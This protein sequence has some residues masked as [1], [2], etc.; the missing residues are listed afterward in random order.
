[1]ETGEPLRLP[2]G[3]A[4]F[5]RDWGVPDGIARRGSMLLVHG[6]GEHS[7]RYEHVAARLAALGLEVRGYDLRG[8]GRS[9]GARGSIPY[10]DA[11][12]DDLSFVFAE[13]ARAAGDSGAPLLLG[14]SLG[15]T[16]AAAA[17]IRGLVAPRALILSSPAL[18]VHVRGPRA[19]ALNLARRLI[20]DR[21]LP[22]ALPLDKLSHE[23]AVVAAYRDDELVHDRITPR[24]YGFLVDAGAAARRGAG[25][26]AVPT[27]LLVAGDDALVDA[28]GSRE[29]AAGLAP[30]VGDPRFYDELYHEVF[31]EREPERTRVL[32]DLCAWVERRLG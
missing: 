24:L 3:T 4:T 32:D 27:L 18:R 10:D 26:L 2:D 12:L 21:P 25:R 22:N 15:G 28:R 20:P 17:T 31:N 23:P 30:G 14:H 13:R 6:L 7:G 1:V 16:I 8:H 5:V 19:T 29:L 11:L 9:A